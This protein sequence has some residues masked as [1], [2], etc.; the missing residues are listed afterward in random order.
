[1]KL[2]CIFPMEY[3]TQQKFSEKN[4]L[5]GK[6]I[7]TF[8]NKLKIISLFGFVFSNSIPN[9]VGT[10]IEQCSAMLASAKFL[11]IKSH[12]S[13]LHIIIKSDI[14]RT[15]NRQYETSNPEPK[16]CRSVTLGSVPV[17][18]LA[19]TVCGG[20]DSIPADTGECIIRPR[21]A[22][23]TFAL[24]AI[25][26]GSGE[27]AVAD[28]EAVLKRDTIIPAGGICGIVAEAVNAGVGLAFE[29]SQVYLIGGAQI[30]GRIYTARGNW[31][32]WL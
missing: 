21:E 12:S 19:V 15:C 6:K 25:Y 32:I 31:G 28:I 7:H 29:L 3:E 14:E 5:I 22:A 1:M 24:L 23:D 27:I 18:R 11:Q 8:I 10:V 17:V 9:T 13:P 30:D 2:Q 20:I 16:S 26:A 4:E